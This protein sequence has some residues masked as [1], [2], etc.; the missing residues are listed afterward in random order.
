MW[1][2]Q[3]GSFQETR[4]AGL[5]TLK[6]VD[7]GT[8]ILNLGGT[9]TLTNLAIEALGNEGSLYGSGITAVGG[10][11]RAD[12]GGFL[13]GD[14][15]VANGAR[16]RV[17]SGSSLGGITVT[18]NGSTVLSG[19]GY[20]L[21]NVVNRA[22]VQPGNDLAPFGV[23]TVYGNYTQEPL[24]VLDVRINGRQEGIQYTKLVVSG[25]V[26]L[27]GTLNARFGFRPDAGDTFRVLDFYGTRT[28]DFAA[29]LTPGLAQDLDASFT[30]DDTGLTVQVSRATAKNGGARLERAN[31]EHVPNVPHRFYGSLLTGRAPAAAGPTPR[32]SATPRRLRRP[33]ASTAHGRA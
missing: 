24:G 6:A 16:V 25:D 27:A 19:S 10:A 17:G 13:Y 31:L 2:S 28:G 30:Y 11:V 14:A 22:V 9:S 23:L 33:G 3:L 1:L 4:T 20:V 18:L 5:S 15:L 32:P 29:K 12:G 8:T 26:V 7:G 21:G